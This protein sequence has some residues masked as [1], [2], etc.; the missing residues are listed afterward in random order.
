[1][2]ALLSVV[3]LISILSISFVAIAQVTPEIATVLPDGS[4]VLPDGSQSV[5][6]GEEFGFV[7]K[8]ARLLLGAANEKRWGLFVSILLMAILAGFNTLLIR[9]RELR[10]RIKAYLG[11][12]AMTMALLGYIGIALAA[13]PA[14]AHVAD[15]FAVIWP[16]VKTGLA[17]VGAYE[18]LAKRLIGFWLPKIVGLLRPKKTP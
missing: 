17:T 1:M 3:A 6:P 2:K 15:W 7:V 12:V 13:L 18:L 9:S 16:A 5:S 14:G 11:E 8:T 10:D 4:V